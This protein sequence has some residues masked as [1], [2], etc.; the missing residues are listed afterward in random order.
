MIP[1]IKKQG[2]RPILANFHYPIGYP[3]NPP[4]KPPGT[5][6]GPAIGGATT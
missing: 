1:N 2:W 6:P 3:G 5:K 4:G